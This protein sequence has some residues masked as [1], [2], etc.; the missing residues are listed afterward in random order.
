MAEKRI[1]L[2]EG[3]DDEHVV[4]NICGR[5]GLGKIDIRDQKGVDP[6]LDTLPVQL[7][8]S[9]IAVLGIMLDADVNLSAR[10][11]AI[12]NRLTEAGYQ[13]ISTCPDVDGTILLPP[14]KPDNLLPKVGIWLMPDNRIPGILEDFLKILIP[15]GDSLLTHADKVIKTLPEQ[16]FTDLDRS[17]ALM[18]TWLAWQKEPGK[19]YGQAITARYLDVNLPLGQTFATWLK[20]CFFE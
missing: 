11:Q 5:Y 16:R 19:P 3:K 4:K 18:H 7:Q 6:L 12:T 1:L 14:E 9:D 13:G 2:V 15:D 8:E 20:N 17:K 10:W